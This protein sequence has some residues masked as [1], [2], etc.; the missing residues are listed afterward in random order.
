MKKIR[1][2]AEAASSPQECCRKTS[3]LRHPGCF[4]ITA[5]IGFYI[6][7]VKGWP[8]LAIGLFGLFCSIYYTVPPVKFGYRGF[9]ELGLLVNFGPVIGL[10]SYYVQAGRFDAEPFLYIPCPGF[11]DVVHDNH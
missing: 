8:V 6:A 4:S 9:G 5:L 7:A 1:I 3:F 10:G 11:H 2:P